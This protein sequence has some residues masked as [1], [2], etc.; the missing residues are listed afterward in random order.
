MAL[1]HQIHKKLKLL[2]S[3]MQYDRMCVP[4]MGVQIAIEDSY[5]I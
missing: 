4:S 2:A 5:L 3:K 1:T